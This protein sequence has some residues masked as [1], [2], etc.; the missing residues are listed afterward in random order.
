MA[1]RKKNKQIEP[2]K[3]PS[4]YLNIKPAIPFMAVI[5]FILGFV[6]CYITFVYYG[7]N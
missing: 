5:G 4:K 3:K 7:G 2:K 1:E 6:I